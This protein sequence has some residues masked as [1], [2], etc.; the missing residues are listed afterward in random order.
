MKTVTMKLLGLGLAVLALPMAQAV[1][2][3]DLPH[4][5]DA[6]WKGVQTCHLLY[7]TATVR[8]GQCSFP[9]GVG[10]EKHYHNPHFGY[11]LEGATMLIQ[12]QTGERAAV[13]EAGSTWSTSQR[14]VHQAFNTGDTTARFL[15]VEPLDIQPELISQ[16]PTT[17]D[18]G[19]KG[20]QLFKNSTSSSAADAT[21]P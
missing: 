16:A 19:N 10:H 9:P 6:G 17:P 11:V 1:D 13:T 12:D 4:A 14:T 20:G 7:E 8:V 3:G 18:Q 2:D 21:E 15:I 5:F